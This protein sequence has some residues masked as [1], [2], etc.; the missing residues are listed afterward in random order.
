MN[1]IYFLLRS[2]WGKVAISIVTGLL[3]GASSA[4]LI[5]LIGSA[6]SPTATSRLTSIAWGFVGLVVVA[7]IT[8][9]VSQ[10]MLTR[11]SQNAVFQLRMRLSHQILSSELSHLERLGNF[12]L[13]ATLTEDV[14]AVSNAVYAIPFLCIDIASVI[15][16]MLYIAWLSWAV[17]LMVCC[18]LVLVMGTNYWLLKAGKTLFRPCS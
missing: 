7:L 10:I 8:S 13:L 5:A 14:Q 2:A 9:V 17:L 11:L 16:C 12:R 6:A 15:G 18:L 3:S 1:L 4:S